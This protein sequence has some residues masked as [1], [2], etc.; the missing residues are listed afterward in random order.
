MNTVAKAVAMSNGSLPSDWLVGL[1]CPGE[2]RVYRWR[3]RLFAAA[4]SMAD[5]IGPELLPVPD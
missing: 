3:S 1:R 2:H 4:W 5:R